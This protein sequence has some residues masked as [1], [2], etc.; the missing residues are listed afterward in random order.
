MWFR[1]SYL[2]V[3]GGGSLLL[4]LGRARVVASVLV[5]LLLLL[6]GASAEHGENIVGSAGGSSRDGAGRVGSSGGSLLSHGLKG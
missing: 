6:L 3:L 4:G 1:S 5:F 2:R